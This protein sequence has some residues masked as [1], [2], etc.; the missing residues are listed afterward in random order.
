MSVQ[1]IAAILLILAL[2]TVAA[3]HLGH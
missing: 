1:L 2:L 3:I